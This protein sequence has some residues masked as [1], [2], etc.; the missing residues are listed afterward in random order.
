MR[1]AT[2]S[3]HYYSRKS[4]DNHLDL[5]IDSGNEMLDHFFLSLKKAK[6]G[7]SFTKGKPH[8]TKYLNYSGKISNNRGRVRVLKRFSIESH[9]DLSSIN[10]QD[11]KH[12]I[13]N[14]S[15]S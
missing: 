15:I 13:A 4:T 10:L 14:H 9:V 7:V 11:I 6:A 5:F 12:F 8:R 3:I 2:L 1:P